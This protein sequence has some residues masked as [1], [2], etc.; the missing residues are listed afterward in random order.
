[1]GTG[2]LYAVLGVS[3]EATQAEIKRAYSRKVREHPPETDPDGFQRISQAYEVL[4]DAK[5]RA[6]YDARSKYDDVVRELVYDARTLAGSGEWRKAAER[7]KRAAVLLPADRSI[8]VLL[9]G[10][11]LRAEMWAEAVQVLQGLCKQ[12]PD[13]AE[14]HH[15]LGRALLGWSAQHPLWSQKSQELSLEGC[16]ALRQAVKVDPAYFDAYIDLA[17]ECMRREQHKDAARWVERALDA[18]DRLSPNDIDALIFVMTLYMSTKDLAGVRRACSR[19]EQLVTDDDACDAAGVGMRIVHAGYQWVAMGAFEAAAVVLATARNVCA[20]DDII[21]A[22]F[23]AS[24]EDDIA[25]CRDMHQLCSD[26][27]VCPPIRVLCYVEVGRIYHSI[28][29]EDGES[30]GGQLDEA[31]AQALG[32]LDHTPPEDVLASLRRISSSYHAAYLPCGDL[33]IEIESAVLANHPRFRRTHTRLSRPGPRPPLTSSQEAQLWERSNQWAR[34]G[35][36]WAAAGSQ[37][38]AAAAWAKSGEHDRA[39]TAWTACGEHARAASEWELAEEPTNAAQAWEAAGEHAKAARLWSDVGD[40]VRAARA[41]SN[42]RHH[43]EAAVLWADIGD[44][45]QAARAWQ[46]AGEH[47]KAASEW[48]L[49]GSDARAAESWEA[50]G[51]YPRAAT[52]WARIGKH[53]SAAAAWQK[54]GEPG[55]AAAHYEEAHDYARAGPL[56]ASLGQHESAAH[57]FERAGDLTRAAAQ[58]EEAGEVVVAAR[59]WGEAGVPSNAAPLWEAAGEPRLAAEAWQAAQRYDRAADLWEHLDELDQAADAWGKAGQHTRAASLWLGLGNLPRAAEEWAEAGDHTSAATMWVGLGDHRLAAEAWT[60]AGEHTTAALQWELAHEASRAARSWSS[61]GEYRRAAILWDSTGDHAEAAQAWERDGELTEAARRWEAAGDYERAAVLWADA[62][63]HD[64][65]AQAF[66]HAGKLDRAASE[67][68]VAGDKRRAIEAWQTAGCHDQAARLWEDLGEPANAAAAWAQACQYAAAASTWH[69]LGDHGLAAQAWHAAGE[70]EAAASEWESAGEVAR[71]AESWSTAGMPQRAAPLWERVGDKRRAAEAW[72]KA[73]RY[74]DAA[75]LWRDLH[76]WEKAANA[77]AEAGQH[78]EAATD[79]SRARQ[80]VRAAEAWHGAGDH[81]RAAAEWQNA[82]QFVRAAQA[83]EAA[84]EYAHAA[85]QWEAADKP[86]LAYQAWVKARHRRGARHA[87]SLAHQ[88]AQQLGTRGDWEQAAIIWEQIGSTR[89]AGSARRRAK[90]SS[91]ARYATWAASMVLLLIA[92][93]IMIAPSVLRPNDAAPH[94]ELPPLDGIDTASAPAPTPQAPNPSTI[95]LDELTGDTPV[96]PDAAGQTAPTPAVIERMANGVDGAGPSKELGSTPPSLAQAKAPASAPPSREF[97]AGR[98]YGAVGRT[99]WP[100]LELLEPVSLS[101]RKGD[102]VVLSLRARNEGSGSARGSITVSADPTV[103]MSVDTYSTKPYS[104]AEG[105]LISWLSDVPEPPKVE[106][107]QPLVELYRH[108]WPA[109]R[110]ESMRVK[111]RFDAAGEVD[112]FVRCTL[113]E[114]NSHRFTAPETGRRDQQGQ[115]ALKLDFDVR[116]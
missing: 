116:P 85:Q 66:E 109:G 10:L 111:L 1:M 46:A 41:W 89:R 69:D 9:G 95:Q 63:C 42:A 43:T 25:V 4:R 79:W 77:F 96:V 110:A 27:R 112:V 101:P 78:A 35:H 76:A 86:G 97:G 50:A 57:A 74:L 53:L 87:R 11:Y 81:A 2:D 5:R 21:K 17:Q 115:P 83:W 18:A 107:D 73:G 3:P 33:L 113:S 40:R 36:A 20:R 102:E 7:A 84:G 114:P 62:G 52:I 12:D 49:A 39:A 105:E 34:A 19:A 99:V 59:T 14:V 88:A 23:M 15:L 55:R 51:D 37:H 30:Q 24:L 82:Q 60:A 48:E 94:R 68:E 13:D 90:R 92:A 108:Q 100:V 75:R 16:E 93:V 91:S 71:A 28:E 80:S 61:A 67:W 29:S 22:E 44:H 65:A 104:K 32:A 8:Q 6:E 106:A 56:W 45:V 47:A 38:K 31:W 70:H 98:W 72:E 64:L 54:G 26:A 58:W 103:R